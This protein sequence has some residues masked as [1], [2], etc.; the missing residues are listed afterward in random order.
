M[1][2]RGKQPVINDSNYKILEKMY[3][4]E[5]KTYE[6]IAEKLNVHRDSVYRYVKKNKMIRVYQSKEWLEDLHYNQKLNLTQI[7]K[8]AH[9][10]KATI[11]N[12]FNR[13]GIE[14]NKELV[15]SSMRS[16]KLNE[17]YFQTIDTEHKAYWL[18]FIIADGNIFKRKDRAESYRLTIKLSKKDSGHLEKFLKDLNC[19]API[20]Y[21]EE[22][23]FE[24][25]MVRINSSKLCKDLMKLGVLPAK[26]CKEKIPKLPSDLQKPLVRGL[27][28]G[29]GCFSWRKRLDT[30]LPQGTFHMCGSRDICEYFITILNT[31]RISVKAINEKREGGLC[32]ISVG[33]NFQVQT[34]M[35]WLYKDST[36]H[37]DRKFK[38]YKSYLNEI[39]DQ[40]YDEYKLKS[41]LH[42]YRSQ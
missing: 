37:L 25:A 9:T 39:N 17:D 22:S 41:N 31:L 14:V 33:G 42:Q 15:C 35:N 6:E 18:G 7:S 4:Y 29:D 26:S 19:N 20:V 24:L 21:K 10:S 2:S 8:L 38:N 34:F 3:C 36:I 28:D 1:M 11:K 32:T 12:Y 40:K 16:Y 23:G 13:F 30:T 5:N 27:F